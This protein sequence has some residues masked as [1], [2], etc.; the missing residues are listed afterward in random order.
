MLAMLHGE[1]KLSTDR[2]PWYALRLESTGSIEPAW[3]C[4]ALYTTRYASLLL[5]CRS[6]FEYLPRRLQ[7]HNQLRQLPPE[8]RVGGRRRVMQLE[9]QRC[10]VLR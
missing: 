5:Y 8:P 4:F 3:T 2:G 10:H 1:V 7:T 9:K 6:I